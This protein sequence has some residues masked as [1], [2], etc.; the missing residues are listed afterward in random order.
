MNILEGSDFGY[1]V[2]NELFFK[3]KYKY[4]KPQISPKEAISKFKTLINK[5]L[6]SSKEEYVKYIKPNLTFDPDMFGKKYRE[7]FENERSNNIWLLKFNFKNIIGK[8]YKGKK[9]IDPTV[10]D[11]ENEKGAWPAGIFGDFLDS[12]MSEMHKYG[13]SYNIEDDEDEHCKYY[14]YGILVTGSTVKINEE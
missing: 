12:I 6:N 1:Q 13:Y 11:E 14:L 4:I 2:L 8:T 9:I 3:R 7:V 10:Y 5:E